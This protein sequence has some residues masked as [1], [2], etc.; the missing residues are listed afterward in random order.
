M[1]WKGTG[2]EIDGYPGLAGVRSTLIIGTSLFIERDHPIDGR[3]RLGSTTDYKHPLIVR[4]HLGVERK[5]SGARRTLLLEGRLSGAGRSHRA[6]LRQNSE[7][8]H[9]PRRLGVASTSP[10]C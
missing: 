10:L 8:R 7:L 1:K 9:D 6:F 4:P 3:V 5:K 2:I